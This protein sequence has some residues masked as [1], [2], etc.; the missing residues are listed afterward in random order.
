MGGAGGGE[1]RGG[2]HTQ[3]EIKAHEIMKEKLTL[4]KGVL[5][6]PITHTLHAIKAKEIRMK[7]TLT[8]KLAIFTVSSREAPCVC[9]ADTATGQIPA[10]SR[11]KK[12]QM[13]LVQKLNN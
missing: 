10:F 12:R 6:E 13:W 4:K 8:Q 3:H 9:F 11:K 1:G 5:W 2:G 7:I